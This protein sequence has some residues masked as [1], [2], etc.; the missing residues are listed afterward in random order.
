LETNE[1]L[2][3]G[4][5]KK[6]NFIF[7]IIILLISNSNYLLSYL[8]RYAH[9]S[10]NKVIVEEFI[11]RLPEY[12]KKYGT[13]IKFENYYFGFGLEHTYLRGSGVVSLGSR[14]IT[15]GPLDSTTKG[16]I[17]HGGMSAD[18]PEI[19]ASLR[20][21]Y[22]PKG[23]YQGKLFLTD[24]GITPGTANPE[25][26]A[27]DWHFTG[28]DGNIWTWDMGKYYIKKALEEND[29]DKSNEY[30][31]NAFRCLGEVL[32]N[33]GDMGLPAHVRNDAHSGYPGLG[34][35]D[36]YESSYNPDWSAKFGIKPCDPNLSAFFSSA[37]RAR[38][39]NIEMSKFTNKYFFSHETISGRGLSN[40]HS[41]T[42]VII[43][44]DDYPSPKLEDF[45]YDSV[46][47]GY[48]KTFPS[49]REVQMCTDKSV[50]T[51]I[52]TTIFRGY[53]K[54]DLTSVE[55]QASELIPN[56]VE[57]GINVMR[58]FIPALEVTIEANVANTIL[59]GKINLLTD[60]EYKDPIYYGGKVYFFV[61]GVLSNVT[62]TANLGEYSVAVPNL[63]AGDKVKAQ[64]FM[65]DIAISS[66]E[67]T[68]KGQQKA[69]TLAPYTFTNS[70]ANSTGGDGEIVISKTIAG[71]KR[72]ATIKWNPPPTGSV[73][74][75]DGRIFWSMNLQVTIKYEDLTYNDGGTV[76]YNGTTEEKAWYYTNYDGFTLYAPYFSEYVPGTT[77]SNTVTFQKTINFKMT[78]P[79]SSFDYKKKGYF[80][81]SGVL[82]GIF[83]SSDN[84]PY[85]QFTYTY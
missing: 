19:P 22:D 15:E 46:T 10:I 16:W 12:M 35:T 72:T 8:N 70:T 17:M 83:G 38:V 54:V 66:K 53:P 18:E 36:P 23:N 14:F 2:K 79:G 52:T 29:V 82:K 13:F 24:I 31:A 11:R 77:K 63:K 1:F 45:K 7:L 28:G 6:I 37:T 60:D 69:I 49:G 80:E 65:T 33:T 78:Y 41:R 73:P 68:L 58:A 9:P 81:I 32:H 44:F 67:I 27:I 61:N 64:I 76:V 20:H 34:G 50:F 4:K 5:M 43:G 71:S 84:D 42:G 26:N 85:F 39:I 62:A 25:V 56:I 40:Y 55:S 48:K 74:V 21:F 51:T 3:E 59:L 47:F 30:Y 75:E 57:A